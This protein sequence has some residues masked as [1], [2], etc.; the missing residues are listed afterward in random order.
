M[1][2]EEYIVR[3][4]ASRVERLIVIQTKRH[5]RQL[6]RASMLSG[7]DTPLRNVWDE[8]CAQTQGEESTLWGA[9]EDLIDRVLLARLGEL[10]R[11]AVLALWLQTETGFD[12]LFDH[13][14]DGDALEQTPVDLDAVVDH[15]RPSLLREAADEDNERVTQYLDPWEDEPDS[16]DDD[17]EIEGDASGDAEDVD[18]SEFRLVAANHFDL[19]LTVV[20]NPEAQKSPN[21]KLCLN[22]EI[23]VDGR[24]LDEPHPIDL[25]L[26]LKSLHVEGVYDIF[27]CSCGESGCARIVEGVSVTHDGD[28]IHWQFRRPQSADGFP[29]GALSAWR[30]AS[31]PVSLSF[32]KGQMLAAFG[33]YLN[34]VRETVDG[35]AKEFSWPV[36]GVTVPD[37]L[38]MDLTNPWRERSGD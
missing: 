3:R 32:G 15:I 23:W 36:V 22:T 8:I 35:R 33:A 16:G 29:V 9:Y 13:H 30:L 37:V 25:P 6:G 17:N 21:G 14:E 2:I 31:L 10:E 7:D 19:R 26:L 5:L 24:H 18:A 4:W 12:W 34:R 20:D 11:A 1:R 38:K 27:T 28:A